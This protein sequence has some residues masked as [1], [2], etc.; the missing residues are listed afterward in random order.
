MPKRYFKLLIELIEPPWMYNCWRVGEG[1]KDFWCYKFRTMVVDADKSKPVHTVEYK[2]TNDERIMAS[3]GWMRRIGFDELPQLLNILKGEM[4]FFGA[5]PIV[6][7]DWEQ[8]N[9]AQKKRRLRQKPGCIGPYAMLR[10]GRNESNLLRANDAYLRIL[11]RKKLRGRNSVIIFNS[12]VFLLT[13]LAIIE[14]KVK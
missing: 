1:E 10:D 7:S 3:R 9:N 8:L 2:D 6:R 14:G 5:R 4:N 11:F 12:R 13:L